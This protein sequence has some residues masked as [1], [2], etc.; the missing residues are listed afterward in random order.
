MARNAESR[1]A[2]RRR[3]DPPTTYVVT[4]RKSGLSVRRISKRNPRVTSHSA[5]G[6]DRL[7]N[8]P[9]PIPRITDCGR[10]VTRVGT[11]NSRYAQPETQTAVTRSPE[12]PET[13]AQRAATGSTDSPTSTSQWLSER[14]TLPAALATAA[15][16]SKRLSERLVAMETRSSP[17]TR[18]ASASIASPRRKRTSS[19]LPMSFIPTRS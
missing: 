8:P 5:D 13:N 16:C 17:V 6:T 7:I 11:K 12:D 18:T 4:P 15:S 19:T 3:G 1:R 10:T 9:G 2:Q 14:M